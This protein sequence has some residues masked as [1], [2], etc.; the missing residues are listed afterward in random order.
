[1][2][3][4]IRSGS[5][6]Y[7]DADLNLDPDSDSDPY[8]ASSLVI[9]YTSQKIRFFLL[10]IHSSAISFSSICHKFLYFGQ[11]KFS[12]KSIVYIWL[13]WIQI[14]IGRPWMP[15]RI[16]I[17]LN[18]A[19]SNDPDPQHWMILTLFKNVKT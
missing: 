4:W 6:F 9:P 13:K 19:D 16:R 14:L 1:M 7:F 5:D 11:L 15:I 2:L 18:V 8:T 17:R 3:I 12:G 10:F